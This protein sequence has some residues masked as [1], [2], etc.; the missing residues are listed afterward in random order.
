MSSSL[1]SPTNINAPVVGVLRTHGGWLAAF[2]LKRETDGHMSFSSLAPL[3]L[4]DGEIY[5]PNSGSWIQGFSVQMLAILM[6]TM[7]YMDMA[8]DDTQS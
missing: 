8:K 6:R 1:M 3:T 7:L 2:E 5:S 4:K